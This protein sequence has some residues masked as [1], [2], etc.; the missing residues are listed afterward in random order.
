[1]LWMGLFGCICLHIRGAA[2]GGY[3][4]KVLKEWGARVVLM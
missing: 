2:G 4:R 1:M 3:S